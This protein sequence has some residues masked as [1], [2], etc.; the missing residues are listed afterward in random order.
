MSLRS[1]ILLSLLLTG[2]VHTLGCG[3]PSVTTPQAGEISQ[4]LQDNPD[5]P[6]SGDQ[7]PAGVNGPGA[8]GQ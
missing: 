5:A 4:Y 1:L 7:E 3:Q 6:V 2:L 8:V